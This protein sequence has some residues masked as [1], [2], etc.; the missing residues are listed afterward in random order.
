MVD[1]FVSVAALLG[2]YLLKS[3][4]LL[5][6]I[7]FG[8]ILLGLLVGFCGVWLVVG[9]AICVCWIEV[10]IDNAFGFND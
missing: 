6:L 5:W 9:T 3:A 7:A 10:A 2:L 1:G 8:L 4:Y